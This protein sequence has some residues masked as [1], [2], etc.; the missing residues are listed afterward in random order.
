MDVGY[1]WFTASLT[2]SGTLRHNTPFLPLPSR[3][4][5]CAAPRVRVGARVRAPAHLSALPN[6]PGKGL[7]LARRNLQA[8][9][10]TSAFALSNRLPPRLRRPF[11]HRPPCAPRPSHSP[12]P[13]FLYPPSNII[14]LVGSIC[15]VDALSGKIQYLCD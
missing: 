14:Y 13:S 5:R 12:L 9:S 11:A 3:R 2:R 15:I 1:L 4:M 7:V 6:R 8:S 10:G